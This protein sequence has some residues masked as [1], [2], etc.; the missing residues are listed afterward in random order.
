[1]WFLIRASDV[2]VTISVVGSTIDGSDESEYESDY[3]M[4][5]LKKTFFFHFYCDEKIKNKQKEET[6]F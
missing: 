5:I 1:M 2:L 3:L 4:E 6:K